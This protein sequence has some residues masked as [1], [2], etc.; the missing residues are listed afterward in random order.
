MSEITVGVLGEDQWREYREIRLAALRDSP[1][2]FGSTYSA[3]V[4]LDEEQWRASMVRAHRL[5]AQRDGTATGVVSV[6][7]SADEENSA[8]LFG[9]WVPPQVRNTG[10]AWRLV[11]AA[12][13]T[14]IKEGWTHLYYWVGS[15]NGR[16]IAFATN[17]GFRVTSNRRSS[18]VPSEEFGDEDIAMVLPTPAS[19]RYLQNPTGPRLA[20]K[21]GPR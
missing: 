3:E 16:A 8:D 18:R 13:E 14:T 20:S 4:D 12:V 7:P 19:G 2:A 10:I 15:Q 6:G 9:L 5:I 11:E 17:F 1:G 21:P